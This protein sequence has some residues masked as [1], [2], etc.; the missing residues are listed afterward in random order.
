MRRRKHEDRRTDFL[1]EV[2]RG[3]RTLK[4]IAA[5]QLIMRR[6][7]RLQKISVESSYDS[8]VLGNDN[9]GLML[10]FSNMVLVAT[11]SYGA[12]LVIDGSLSVGAL[13]A[14]TTLAGRAVQPILKLFIV[15]SQMAER[16]TG[17][18]SSGGS[19]EPAAGQECRRH[20]GG[21][22]SP[23]RSSSVDLVQLSRTRDRP[24]FEALNLTIPAGTSA[25]ITGLDLAGKS[26]LARLLAGEL[27]PTS[28][29]IRHR[30]V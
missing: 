24:I 5:E 26:T 20:S 6:H 8:L 28:G 4:V 13:A 16:P 15:H 7:D 2:L 22:A 30:S 14:C 21:Q 27:A 19:A 3:I 10:L 18:P 17:A 9:Q 12:I 1:I 11:V 23:A 29:R 25:A